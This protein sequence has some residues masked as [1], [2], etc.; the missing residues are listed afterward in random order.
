[1]TT[2][3][4]AVLDESNIDNSDLET[5]VA[6][7]RASIE[8]IEK[9]SKNVESVVKDVEEFVKTSPRFV[10]VAMECS[11]L[12]AKISVLRE[13]LYYENNPDASA[14]YKE[15]QDD[16]VDNSEE[17]EELSSRMKKRYSALKKKIGRLLHPDKTQSEFNKELYHTAMFLLENLEF[18]KL[19]ELLRNL[20]VSRSTKASKFSKL[21]ARDTLRSTLDDLKLR[22]AALNSELLQK[23]NSNEGIIYNVA[24]QYGIKSHP[25]FNTVLNIQTQVLVNLRQ[26]HYSLQM[27]LHMLRDIRNTK[28]KF[29]HDDADFTV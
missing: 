10:E 5:Q 20:E 19:E 3:L 15:E 17:A 11:E 12:S 7:Y 27:K 26:E 13:Q 25:T 8:K 1:M 28:Q 2:N 24:S 29:S 9:F 18:D 6:F 22:Y 21:A 23:L 16:P 14:P 4:P